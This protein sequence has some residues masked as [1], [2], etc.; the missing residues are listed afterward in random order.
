M[1]A[2]CGFDY[3]EL[4]ALPH[5]V[6]ASDLVGLATGGKDSPAAVQLPGQGHLPMG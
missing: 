2:R 3:G 5:P 6:G 4:F 1:G